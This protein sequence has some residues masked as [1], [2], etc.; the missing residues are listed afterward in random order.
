M[1]RQI[2]TLVF[3]G[4]NIFFANAQERKLHINVERAEFSSLVM[5]FVLPNETI[6]LT[7]NDSLQWEI[8]IPDSVF[9]NYQL[10]GI[11]GFQVDGEH[12]KFYLSSDSA[13]WGG[14]D[15]DDR[16]E[17]FLNLEKIEREMPLAEGYQFFRIKE[18]GSDP[19]FNLSMM[20]G[21]ISFTWW[22]GLYDYWKDREFDKKEVWDN[23]LN[24]VK[25][26]PDSYTLAKSIKPWV[27]DF[28]VDVL[29]Q[30]YATFSER[31]QKSDV[32]MYIRDFYERKAK[33]T[34]FE[35]IQ[36]PDGKTG[37]EEW[38]LQDTAHYNLVLFSAS[39]CRPCHE[40]IPLLKEIYSDLHD[41]LDMVYISADDKPEQIEAWKKLMEKE[42]IPWRSLITGEKM[43]EVITKY[44][45]DAFPTAYLIQPDG[46]FGKIEIQ[47]E[48]EKARLYTLV[49]G[50]N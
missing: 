30:L 20:F 32:G 44:F 24:L 33:F 21:I 29:Q 48:T 18:E 43:K 19:E 7:T 28:S 5:Y 6:K 38:V 46:S 12:L 17:L 15:L 4:M 41:N 8:I 2:I 10:I 31:V 47:D 40:L 36:L 27:N 26:Y 45:I 42:Q 3:L 13:A 1:K 11:A 34:S 25:E 35:N 49:K 50:I 16:K 22:Q 23:Y 37:K 39:W 9:F 14:F